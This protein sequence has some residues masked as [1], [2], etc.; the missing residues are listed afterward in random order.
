MHLERVDSCVRLPSWCLSSLTF[1]LSVSLL[2]LLWVIRMYK[3]II[4]AINVRVDIHRHKYTHALW[5]ISDIIVSVSTLCSVS[6]TKC[7]HY[8]SH[9]LCACLTLSPFHLTLSADPISILS[10]PRSLFTHEVHCI[11]QEVWVH[12]F[13][14]SELN[15]NFQASQFWTASTRSSR[16]VYERMTSIYHRIVMQIL[17]T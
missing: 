11:K 3:A 2:V 12:M 1:L 10:H 5:V 9:P 17:K 14:W 4:L 7:D 13:Y 16:G 15:T 8:V 6:L